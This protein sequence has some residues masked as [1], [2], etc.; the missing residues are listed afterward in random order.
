[1][2][3]AGGGDCLVCSQAIYVRGMPAN[4]IMVR[5]AWSEDLRGEDLVC[6]YSQ[7]P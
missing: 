4:H 1:M 7:P 3:I 5:I 2:R 6:M